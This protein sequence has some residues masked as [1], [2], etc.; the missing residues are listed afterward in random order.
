MGIRE[1]LGWSG[2]GRYQRLQHEKPTTRP[3]RRWVK[4]IM[5]GKVAGFRMPSTKRLNWRRVS[6]ILVMPRR[7]AGMYTEL[8]RMIM[9]LEGVYP[10]VTFSSQWGLPVI[11]YCPSFY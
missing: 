8:E 11:S 7:I 6:M 1:M 5:N 4:R 2:R 10:T 3:R 9:K